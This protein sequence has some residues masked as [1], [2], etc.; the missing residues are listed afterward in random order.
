MSAIYTPAPLV[1]MDSE[2][3]NKLEEELEQSIAD[4]SD[5][6]R[7]EGASLGNITESLRA[8]S[9]QID[10]TIQTS[11]KSSLRHDESKA[12]SRIQAIFRGYQVRKDLSGDDPREGSRKVRKSLDSLYASHDGFIKEE[13]VDPKEDIEQMGPLESPEFFIQ[14]EGGEVKQA[15]A[16]AATKIQSIF[17]GHQ[18]RKKFR[19]DETAELAEREKKEE[20][21]AAIKIQ[22]VFRGHKARKSSIVF[23]KRKNSGST[24]V[25]L[26]LGKSEMKLRMNSRRSMEDSRI[27]VIKIWRIA[28]TCLTV[29]NLM[30]G[31]LR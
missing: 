18:A 31:S 11:R 17:R 5:T 2:M 30:N 13:Y 28:L 7:S 27:I 20:A 9:Q 8:L 4:L 6:Q 10:V 15:E 16:E 25:Y 22:A 24:G 26:K 14:E 23:A 21:K 12:A 3:E 29:I 19:F 1:K